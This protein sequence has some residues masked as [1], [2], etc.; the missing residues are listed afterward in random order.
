MQ[1]AG[2]NN[3]GK[4]AG[5]E[6]HGSRTIHFCR[7]LPFWGRR[8]K[9]DADMPER[10]RSDFD[11]TEVPSYVFAE[12][13]HQAFVEMSDAVE[14]I[15]AGFRTPMRFD[16]R[17]LLPV[18]LKDVRYAPGKGAWPI[19]GRKQCQQQRNANGNSLSVRFVCRTEARER[20][21]CGSIAQMH[22][23]AAANAATRNFVA[24][25]EN[26]QPDC[27]INRGTLL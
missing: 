3:Y 9:A 8:L 5:R 1:L 22:R 6:L 21:G 12:E 23:R 10:L 18:A 25:G 20:N 13:R 7:D 16:R 2:R 24:L 15:R 4:G 19:L 26:V 11:F 27:C 17:F 14:C